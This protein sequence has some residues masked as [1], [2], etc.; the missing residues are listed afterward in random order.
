[1][2]GAFRATTPIRVAVENALVN[3]TDVDSEFEKAGGWKAVEI[4]ASAGAAVQ[5]FTEVSDRAISKIVEKNIPGG[6]EFTSEEINK[7]TSA[8]KK[9]DSNTVNAI[10][11]S[12]SNWIDFEGAMEIKDAMEKIYKEVILNELETEVLKEIIK[13]TG[14]ETIKNKK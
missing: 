2:S 12:K 14:S 11:K 10:I 5:G 4:Q 6:E 1:M 13:A 8:L 7:I 9:G 3:G